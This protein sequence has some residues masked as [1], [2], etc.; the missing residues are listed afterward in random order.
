MNF[1]VRSAF[2]IPNLA[3]VILGLKR[4]S[5]L[6]SSFDLEETN[7]YN[8]LTVKLFWTD[9]STLCTN[10]CHYFKDS[11]ARHVI[12]FDKFTGRCEC[13][14]NAEQNLFDTS[15]STKTVTAVYFYSGTFEIKL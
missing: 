4:I 9:H 14:L 5:Y 8:L 15:N 10:K 11:E 6:Q 13:F 12:K 1:N 2:F 3:L 7:P